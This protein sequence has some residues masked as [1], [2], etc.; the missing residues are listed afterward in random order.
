MRLN[1]KSFFKLAHFNKNGT[2][3]FPDNPLSFLFMIKHHFYGKCLSKK[4]HIFVTLQSAFQVMLWP[5]CNP[6]FG[7]A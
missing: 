7:S 3:F 5:C 4:A 1:V 2:T 6:H